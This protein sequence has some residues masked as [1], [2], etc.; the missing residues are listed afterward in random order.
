VTTTSQESA[1]TESVAQSTLVGAL[2]DAWYELDVVLAGLT[3]VEMIEPWGGGSAF[4]WTYGHIANSIDAW[5]NVRFQ[6]R[7]P[8][9]VIGDRDL[10][11]GGSGRATDWSAI[12][13]GVAEV[14]ATA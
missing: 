3:P 8:H 2:F 5:V 7:A 9:P 6:G 11:F 10:R 4:A 12:R 14:R 13:R 1:G